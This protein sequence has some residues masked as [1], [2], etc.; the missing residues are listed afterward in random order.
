MNIRRIYMLAI[1]CEEAVKYGCPNCGCDSWIRDNTYRAN[2]PSGKCKSCG[3]AY[4]I[5]A[6][7]ITES[8]V[9]F[10]TNRKDYNGKQIFEYPKL[11]PHPRRGIPQWHYEEPDIRPESGGEYWNSRG[12]GYDL[13][14]FVKSKQAGERILLLV[15]EVLGKDEPASW[16]DYRKNEPSWIQFKFQKTEFDLKKLDD[17]TRSNGNIITK[18]ILVSCKI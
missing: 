17:M 3:V 5:F 2:Q 15:K 10:G 11:I 7:G 16:L 13:S 4:Q 12:I 9:G 6:E 8:S 1:N 18:D 14:G